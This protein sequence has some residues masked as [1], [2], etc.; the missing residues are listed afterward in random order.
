VLH[1]HWLGTVLLE[2]AIAAVLAALIAGRER[3]V[4]PARR[5]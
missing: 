3:M 4:G 5:R 2:V 1:V